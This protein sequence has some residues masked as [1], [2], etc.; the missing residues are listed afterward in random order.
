MIR[1]VYL[2]VVMV[3]LA[4]LGQAGIVRVPSA[5]AVAAPPKSTKPIKPANAKVVMIAELF[6]HGARYPTLDMLGETDVRENLG[7]L[8]ATG[9]RQHYNLGKAIRNKYPQLFSHQYKKSQSQ[10]QSTHID[11][12]WE[13]AQSH[14]MG[15]YPLGSGPKLTTSNKRV[16]T[17]PFSKNNPK[18]HLPARKSDFALPEG[19]QSIPV[20]VMPGLDLD[21]K[22]AFKKITKA[23]EAMNPKWD[24]AILPISAEL[25]KAGFDPKK[26]LGHK[27]FTFEDV[28]N[29]YDYMKYYYFTYAKLYPKLTQQLF[30]MI[31]LAYSVRYY[32]FWRTDEWKRLWSHNIA[33]KVMN[34]FET[35]VENPSHP[36]NYFGMS[37]HDWQLTPFVIKFGFTSYDCLWDEMMS[38]KK[39]QNCYH[40]I[41]FASNI[42]WELSELPSKSN[43]GTEYLV[44]MTWDGKHMFGCEQRIAG[45]WL[46]GAPKYEGYC[47]YDEFR[48]VAKGMFMFESKALFD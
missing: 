40:S 33:V 3:L 12:A 14:M 29:M 35:K 18:S 44:R 41:E 7:Q 46:G 43:G 22:I 8:T 28:F 6:R 45:K 36:L 32:S 9:M 26:L 48:K 27:D 5:N 42:I 19:F 20:F 2:V 1:P 31:E 39:N 17:P 47:T 16:L 24:K 13:S 21:C 11:R 23:S 4:G 37:A 30:E 34:V 15:I 25:K 10:M 38:L